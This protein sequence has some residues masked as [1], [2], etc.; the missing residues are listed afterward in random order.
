VCLSGPGHYLR[1][2]QTRTLMETEFCCPSIGDCKS[3]NEWE[4]QGAFDVLER[5]ARATTDILASHYL[6][7]L[8]DAIGAQI[9]ARFPV[10]LL[11]GRMQTMA[12]P[13]TVGP[14]PRGGG[15]RQRP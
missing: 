7:H 15:T 2:D 6:T 13:A 9:R 4:E 14:E 12:D 11:R 3:P 5:A 8:P 10:R 1:S